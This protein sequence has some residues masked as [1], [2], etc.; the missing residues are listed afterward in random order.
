MLK[1]LSLS[2]GLSFVLCAGSLA[3]AGHHGGA[4]ASEQCASEQCVTASPQGCAPTC[5]PKVKKH[6]LADLCAKFKPKPK[7]YS[8]TWVLK[9][10]RCGGG[11]FGGHCGHSAPTPSCET[12]GVYGSE[13][14]PSPQGGEVLGT[15][16]YAPTSYGSSQYAPTSYGSGQAYAA[17]GVTSAPTVAP[18][19]AGDEAPPRPGRPGRQGRGPGPSR[20]VDP[21]GPPGR[22]PQGLV[23][24]QPALPGPLREL[25]EA[26]SGSPGLMAGPRSPE[27]T[28]APAAWVASFR[29]RAG[30]VRSGVG[31][32][33][34]RDDR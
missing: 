25:S 10:K 12:C 24:Q 16:Q 27:A 29:L 7:C 20:P 4:V 19:P 2:L 31:R 32:G 33:R 14:Y 13:Q 9:K 22:R 23:Q 30:P 17:P 3:L 18:A 6:C 11:L 1:P 21:A 5:A 8:Y 15:S 26:D 34:M 28:H